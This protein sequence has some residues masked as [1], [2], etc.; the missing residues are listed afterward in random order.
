[1][2]KILFFLALIPFSLLAQVET[3]DYGDITD[4]HKVCSLVGQNRSTLNTTNVNKNDMPKTDTI[5]EDVLERILSVIGASKRFKMQE[6]S[7]IDNAL[8]ITSEGIR[9]IL[10]NSGFMSSFSVSDDW[11][12]LFILAHEIGH[13]INGHVINAG[14]AGATADGPYGSSKGGEGGLQAY[15]K[16]LRQYELES[17]EFAA[18][19]LTE[20]GAELNEIKDIFSELKEEKGDITYSTHPKKSN[21]LKAVLAGYD[22][23]IRRGGSDYF[24]NSYQKGEEFFYAGSEK[25]KQGDNY[26][27]LSAYN[28]AITFFSTHYNHSINSLFLFSNQVTYEIKEDSTI[29]LITNNGDIIAPETLA[30]YS[31]SN[32]PYILTYLNRAKIKHDMEDFY[33]AISDYSKVIELS[34]NNVTAYINRGISKQNI[35]DYKASIKD[36]TKYIELN[37]YIPLNDKEFVELPFTTPSGNEF[38]YFR[39]G[40]S[41]YLL[42]DYAGA[43]EDFSIAIKLDPSYRNFLNRGFAKY[44][45]DNEDYCSDFKK[46]SSLSNSPEQPI[47]EIIIDGKNYFL[48]CL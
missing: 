38:A 12:N 20:L 1:M 17:D 42:K 33:G 16:S 14:Y 39:R 9:Y 31:P 27:A 45:N 10:Y 24:A 2:K 19:I 8:A 36:F 44:L 34:P 30:L 7:N 48:N 11:P 32:S 25:E 28:Q 46:A 40:R 26:G 43:I 18:F 15:L 37:P 6:C 4:S 23:S 21:R 5:N 22:K 3:S 47:T 13:H 35:G 29:E 41:K